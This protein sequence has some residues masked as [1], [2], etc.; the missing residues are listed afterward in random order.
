ME[1]RLPFV[2]NKLLLAQ[3]FKT[4]YR[5]NRRI[6]VL[7]PVLGTIIDVMRA[8]DPC[9]NLLLLTSTNFQ[10]SELGQA[11]FGPRCAAI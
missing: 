1:G 7:V 6:P 8:F 9:Y 5:R 2:R 3:Y 4:G 11:D 10:I